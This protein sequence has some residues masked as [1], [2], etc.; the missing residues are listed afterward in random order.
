[1]KLNKLIYEDIQLGAVFNFQRAITEA[2][3]EKFAELTGDT[4]PL[5][6]D[7]AY[8]RGTEFG[9]R[10][11]HG[12]FLGSLFSTLVGMM[13]PGERAL[14][15]SQELKFIKPVFIGEEVNVS[16]RVTSKSDAFRVIELETIIKNKKDEIVVSGSARIKIRE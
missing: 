12:M 1:M 11:V 13:A 15:L 6:M 3:V 2:D 7:E 9:G 5:H 4:S 8:A 10:I 16:G 14:Y